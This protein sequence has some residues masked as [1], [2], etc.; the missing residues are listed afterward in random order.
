[1]E[2]SES[3]LIIQDLTP[4]LCAGSAEE[5]MR[6]RFILQYPRTFSTDLDNL[7]CEL[8]PQAHLLLCPRLSRR[9]HPAIEGHAPH[10]LHERERK[11]DQLDHGHFDVL[12]AS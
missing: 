3:K 8:C 7:I 12:L 2:R 5:K 1:M 9:G 4:C 10:G 11:E 6:L